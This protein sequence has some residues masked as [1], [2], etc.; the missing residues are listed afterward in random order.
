MPIP[1]RPCK[2]SAVPR[3]LSLPGAWPSPWPPS[4]PSAWCG[5]G[6][7]SGKGGRKW[8]G[9]E[10]GSNKHT[11]GAMREPDVCVCVVGLCPYG[12]SPQAVSWAQQECN[13]RM[14][15][16]VASR[17]STNSRR[18]VVPAPLSSVLP[19][20]RTCTATSQRLGTSRPC[21][22]RR[23]TE[24][25]SMSGCCSRLECC[26]SLTDACMKSVQTHVCRHPMNLDRH[27]CLAC[28]CTMRQAMAKQPCPC[29]VSD[30][31]T[32]T[33]TV[34]QCRQASPGSDAAADRQH[35]LEVIP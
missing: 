1:S 15:T 21:S 6:E 2:A 5:L 18:V 8:K 25:S 34:A 3:C 32:H 4:S 12:W 31:Q 35:S 22:N 9:G 16:R 17:A 11:E 24:H 10:R 20:P 27:S 26:N 23:T 33:C 19:L 29:K 30:T 7:G 28:T 13:G 14:H